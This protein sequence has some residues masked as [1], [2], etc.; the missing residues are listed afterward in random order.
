[1]DCNYI[2]HNIKNYFVFTSDE[3]ERMSNFSKDDI[4]RILNAYNNTVSM[5]NEM[6]DE[7]K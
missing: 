3:I 2:V 1:M 5:F 4:A 7:F 6:I